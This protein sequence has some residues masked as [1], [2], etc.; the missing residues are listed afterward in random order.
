MTGLIIL[1]AGASTRMGC[2]K[3]DLPY[4]G[5]TFLQ[6]AIDTAIASHCS[7]VIV[8][9][10]AHAVVISPESLPAE[11]VAMVDN[12]HWQEG[13]SSSIRT[14]ISALQE[15][16]PGATGVIL[17]LCDQPHVTAEHLNGLMLQKLETGK[18]IVASYYDNTMGVPALFDRS[19]FP[20][21]LALKGEEGAK[22]LLY[23]YEDE[24]TAVPF[25]EGS[26]D[27]DTMED[28]RRL[29]G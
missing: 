15:K 25:P 27:V 28:F 26:V 23:Q 17:M 12:P 18:G 10:G 2:A 16:A 3:Q 29:E 21:L 20:A 13:M 14:G 7:P 5:K 22:K 4:K 6:H 19:F 1:A 8:V 24:V 11:R 9:L